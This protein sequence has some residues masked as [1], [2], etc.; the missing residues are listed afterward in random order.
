MPSSRPAWRNMYVELE[1]PAPP[2]PNSK[3]NEVQ[4]IKC[5]LPH[6]RPRSETPSAKTRREMA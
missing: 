4:Q 3:G 1:L 2:A 5:L 6:D